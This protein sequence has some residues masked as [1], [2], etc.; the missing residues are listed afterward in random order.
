MRRTEQT[1]LI[2][3]ATSLPQQIRVP[4]AETH[5][6]RRRNPITVMRFI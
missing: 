4:S 6:A 5:M 3:G 2:G 1:T